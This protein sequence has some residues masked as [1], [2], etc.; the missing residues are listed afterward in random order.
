MSDCMADRQ[1][2]ACTC[3]T[4]A[5]PW[6]RLALVFMRSGTHQNYADYSLMS[7]REAMAEG[8]EFP[9]YVFKHRETRN[10]I[11]VDAMGL[12]CWVPLFSWREGE[13]VSLR[14]Q[15]VPMKLAIA[16]KHVASMDHSDGWD[17]CFQDARSLFRLHAR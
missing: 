8:V 16:V 7:K 10:S 11:A 12:G 5:C 15:V 1:I 4:P 3:G 9:L 2:N 17:R 14:R 6:E 13:D